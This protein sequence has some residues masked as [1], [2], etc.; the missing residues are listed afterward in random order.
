MSIHRSDAMTTPFDSGPAATF[1]RVRQ[2]FSGGKYSG[3][4]FDFSGEA[5]SVSA[6]QPAICSFQASE[7]IFDRLAEPGG[8]AKAIG[9]SGSRI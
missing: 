3:Q 4:P 8:F 9:A 1:R 6:R 5:T 2:R 7:Y